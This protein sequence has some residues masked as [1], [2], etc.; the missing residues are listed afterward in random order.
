L[1]TVQERDDFDIEYNFI[2]STNGLIFEG[3]NW[4]FHPDNGTNFKDVLL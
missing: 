3:R 4:D 1:Q 2:I